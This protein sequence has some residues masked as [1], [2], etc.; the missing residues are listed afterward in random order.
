MKETF[1]YFTDLHY[2][3]YPP[4]MRKE[5][6]GQQ[7][8]QKLRFVLD[9]ADKND[10]EVLFG[11][12]MFHRKARATWTELYLIT[13]ILSGSEKQLHMIL[14]NHDIQG[15]NRNLET[16]PVGVLKEAGLVNIIPDDGYEQFGGVYIT[17]RNYQ[18]D[19]EVPENFE[20]MLEK[21]DL[22]YHIHLTHGMVTNKDLPYNAV[23]VNDL[24][25]GADLVLNGH[26]HGQWKDEEKGFYNP[27]SVARVAMEK[28]E[29]N[30]QPKLLLIEVDSGSAE[31]QEID[32]PVDKDVW[33]SQI[34][35]ERET[36]DNEEVEEF[37]KQIQEMNLD[38]DKEILDE[39]LNDRSEEVRQKVYNYLEEVR[40]K[41][42]SYLGD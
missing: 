32:I 6:Y 15:Y 14:G 25:I 20:C 35:H 36:L 34:L 1:V 13:G 28:N 29:I 16:Q 8:L 19:Y 38:S 7:I 22:L 37:A 3:V 17:G 24:N 5:G 2:S 27:G 41:V 21:P 10:A 31:I 26:N 18:Y 40:Q 9:I 39:L 23:N 4:R 11:G 12:D 42:Y 33:L 30:K